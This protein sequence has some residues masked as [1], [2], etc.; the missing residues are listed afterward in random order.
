MFD[1]EPIPADHWLLTAPR[2]LLSPHMG[3]VSDASYRVYFTDVVANI[4]AYAAGT[5]IRTLT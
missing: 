4:E 2:T 1:I 5:P 3:Y